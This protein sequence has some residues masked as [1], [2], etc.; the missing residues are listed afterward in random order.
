MF[1]VWWERSSLGGS[2]HTPE[3]SPVGILSRSVLV[4]VEWKRRVPGGM[5]VGGVGEPDAGEDGVTPGGTRTEVGCCHV[6][7][8]AD[9][10]GVSSR[11]VVIYETLP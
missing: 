10:G 9:R 2:A 1:G 11:R 8:R 7:C 5:D 4:G 3:G 6:G